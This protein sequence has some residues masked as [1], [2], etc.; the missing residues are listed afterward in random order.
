MGPDLTA[1]NFNLALIKNGM[2]PEPGQHFAELLTDAGQLVDGLSSK[3]RNIIARLQPPVLF[4]YGLESALRWFT[5]QVMRRAGITIAMVT[6]G[7]IPRLSANQ[8]LSLFRIAKEAITNAAKY[9]GAKNITVTL[10]C[11]R[12]TVRLSV[13][14]NGAGFDPTTVSNQGA[15]GWGLTI[16]RMRTEQMGGT[17]HLETAPGRGARI[18]IEIPKEKTDAD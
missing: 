16:M 12:R 17:F 18:H 2:A 11:T 10:G 14:D 5:S 15:G 13:G 7:T 4:D 9:S 1:L 3:V 8:E 6:E